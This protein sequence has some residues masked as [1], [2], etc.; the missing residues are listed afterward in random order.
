MY[1]VGALSLPK[2]KNVCEG[3]TV[4]GGTVP[5]FMARKAAGKRQDDHKEAFGSMILV[6]GVGL[7]QASR[8]E[9]AW[10]SS[11]EVSMSLIAILAHLRPN[12]VAVS[13]S[14]I[15]RRSM[16][17]AWWYATEGRFVRRPQVVK[18]LQRSAILNGHRSLVENEFVTVKVFSSVPNN[19][20]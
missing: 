8:L 9:R 16:V 19:S 7:G 13:V 10:F 3:K 11:L 5:F 6:L 4:M 12:V 1:T 17:R 18:G 2:H 15:A 20:I 14:M